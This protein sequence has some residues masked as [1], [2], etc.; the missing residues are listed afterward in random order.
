MVT[1]VTTAYTGTNAS[2]TLATQVVVDAT[3]LVDQT[4]ATGNATS[5][6]I[7]SVTA[8]STT[9]YTGTAPNT[10]PDYT[11]PSATNASSG[12]NYQWYLGNPTTTGVALTDAGVYSGTQTAVLNISDVTGLDGNEYFLEVTHNSNAC[13]TEV[14]S[15]ILNVS[16][17]SDP[18]TDGTIVGTPTTNDPDGDGINNICDLDDD[19]D[20]ILDTEECSSDTATFT[21]TTATAGEL[22]LPSSG[23]TANWGIS[24]TGQSSIV[25]SGISDNNE[26]Y[27]VYNGAGGSSG[28]DLTSIFQISSI[29]S[30]A[31]IQLRLDGFV[32]KT[33]PDFNAN[34]GSRFASYT[35]SWVGGSGDAILFDPANQIAGGGQNISNGNSFSQL[36]NGDKGSGA[37]SNNLL[38]WYVIFPEGATEF[39]INATGGAALEGFRFSAVENFCPD[40]DDDGIPDNLDLDSD[41]DGCNDVIESGGTDNNNDG[42]LDGTGGVDPITSSTSG[43]VTGGIGGYNG[44]TGN[45]SVAT[46]VSITTAVT[47]QMVSNG[48]SVTFSV[49]ASGDQ[50]TSYSGGTPVY[51]TL[52]NANLGINY[53]WYLGNPDT[54]GTPIVGETN[55]SLTFTT[56]L[57]DDGNEYFVVITHDDNLCIRQVNSATLTILNPSIN[58]DKT[59]SLDLGADGVVSVGDVITY[60]YTVTNTGNVTVFDV[61]VTEDASNFTG[62]GSL[63]TPTYVSGGSDQD[64]ESD[65]ADLAV[66]TGTVLYTATYAITQADINAGI[67]TNQAEASG[68]DPNGDPVNDES[69]DPND[70]TNADSN[71]DGNPDDP[72]DT[73]I[74]QSPSI[75]ID[76]TSSLDLGTDGVVSVG[77]VITYTYTVT[78]T[79]NVTVFDVVVT[80]DASNFTGS[81]SLPSPT[82]VS[83]GSD[84]DG[85]SDIADLAVGTGTILYTATYAITQADINAGIITNQAVAS[86]TDPNGDPVSD[87][88]DDP[89]DATNADSNGDGNP[90]DPTDT[91]IPQSPSINIDKT[92]SLDLGTDGVVSVGD[93]ITY[94]YTVTNT[95]NVTVFDVVVTEDA[96]NFTGSGSLPSPTYVSGGSDQDG[97]SD[98]A[99]LAVGTGTILYT[100]TYAITQ[101]DINAGI[102]TNQA[103]ASGTDPNGDPVSDIS[104]DPN[105][106]TNADSNG[107]GNPDDPTDTTIPQSPS[108]NID[109][110]SSLDLGTDGVVSVGDVITYTYTVTN[111]GNVTVFDVVVTEDASNFTGSGSLPSPTYVSGGSD[112][113]GESDI[114]DLAVGTGTILYTATY[115]ITQADINAGIMTN[116][117]VASGTG[118]NGDPVSDE[119]DDPNDATNADSNGDGNPD[120]PTDTTIPQSPSIN[121]DK[122]SSLDLGTDGVVS[123]G[124]VITYTYTVTNT[125]N[126]TVFDVVVTEDASNFTGSGSL[127]SPAY[128]SGG[129]DQDGESDIADL[130]VGTGTI[131]YTATYAITQADINAGIIT[132]QAVASGTD[133]NG[134]PVSDESDDPND[135][136]NADSNGDGNPDDPTDTTIPQSPSINIDKTSSLDLGTDGVVSVGDVITY[137][138]TVTNTGNVTV[139]DVV[140][141]EDASNFTG[142]GSLPSPTYVSGGSDQDGE[143]DI[144]DLAVGTGTI[145]Y[146]AT[147]AITQADIN[148]GI[149]TNQAVASGTGPNGDPVSDESDDPND[150]TN[151][152]SNGDGNP[153]DPTDTTIP[154][155]PSINIDKTSSLD[156]GTDG[157]VS[158]GDVITYTY[159]VTN[160]GNVTVFDVVVTED[161]SNFTGSGSL[162]SP[163]YV[164]G[165]SDQDGES[166]IADLAV[167]TGTILYTATYAI[168]QADINAGIITNQAVA[169]GTDPNGDPV[170]D[171]SDD[172]N[173]ATNADSNGDGN[174]DDPTDT[175]IPQSPS[176]NIDKTSSL[177]LG[178][179]GVVSVGDVITYTYTVT[180]TGNVTVFDVVVTEDAS[181][182]TGSGS[183]PSPAYVSGGSDQDGE[184][185]IADLAVGTGTILYTATYAITQADINA[186]IITNQAVASGTD[187]NGDPVSDES[188]DP[189]DATNADSNGDGNPDD[190]TDTT[191]PQSPSIN[192]DKTSSLDLG[193]DGVV[194]VGDVITYTYTVTNTGNVT[195]FDVVVTEDAS[196]FTGSGSLP[197]PTYVSGGSDQDGESDI[198]DLAVGTGTILYTATYAITQADINAGIITNQAVASGTDPNGDPV[199][200]ESDDPN[201]TTNADSNGDGNP[202]D[203]TVVI[204]DVSFNANDDNATTD[205]DTPI[206]IDIT[207]NDDNLPTDGTIDII[208]DPSNGTVVI[209]DGGTPD[210]PS[211]DTVTYIPDTDFS[212]TDTFVYEICDRATPPNCTTATVTVIVNPSEIDVFNLISDDGDDVN[213]TLFISGIENYPN[214]T[215]EI[216]NRWGNTVYKAQRYNNT[217]V[218][219]RGESNGRVTI[220]TA[221]K[222]PP[223]TYFYVVDLGDGSEPKSG[224]LYINR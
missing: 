28:W 41:N 168:T 176:I 74:P 85:E 126:V 51:G 137:T 171:E 121:I 209:N 128:V 71:G 101:A 69:D 182:F 135:A 82:Y 153:D 157:V 70:T 24:N 160:T 39:T 53:Q 31:S 8:T 90:D 38:E 106:A 9:V 33:S 162:P 222:L 140:V 88:S 207:D 216:Y 194:S 136:T 195:V 81:G 174:P 5:F 125:G 123:V 181:N 184:S 34:F 3:A 220:N 150:A 16:M 99:D 102:I 213:S 111:T 215:V 142:S 65:I 92:S 55:S 198:A 61:V 110:T 199:S 211:D 132:N 87:E 109:K 27:F 4:I 183:L 76:K 83:G 134:D 36:N 146:T 192:I 14:N 59:S 47:N 45:E 25:S 12:V 119:S 131:L 97:E 26:L 122:T 32:D 115:A 158:V 154:Q 147:Y 118:P 186:G 10:L 78:N 155:S 219:F 187:P 148:A 221:E 165:G 60:T 108:I 93:V 72:T 54:T 105:D 159:T 189:N 217:T 206:D 120:D 203:P 141:T 42:F 191:I 43:Q 86:G 210:D 212:S 62:S 107:D 201:D 91:T 202:D 58:I 23:G 63:P 193:T 37:W 139:F 164:S 151:A 185:D 11:D 100:A 80:E 177:D 46:Q 124:D 50:A 2:L 175:T 49:V 167:G 21:S 75:N 104:D 13:V 205:F 79:G 143:S 223:G 163:T 224:W 84:Q 103:V 130:A 17:M 114:A 113:D 190:P 204:L 197:S 73:T 200:D 20:G 208:S 30:G 48:G 117:A 196:N 77:D 6:T 166:D 145:L 94:T 67:I 1:G 214:N 218:S 188:D 15:A 66:G 161:A 19:N 40:T 180:N 35:I 156:L 173:D 29:P 64:G 149:I 179:D 144:A 170:S 22:T 178:T 44:V 138:Y 172:P 152:D 52:G 96:S 18:C 68:T 89:N 57:A 98:I 95:G 7:T 127:P 56:T 116:Q 169:S 133:P 112:Q 129:S